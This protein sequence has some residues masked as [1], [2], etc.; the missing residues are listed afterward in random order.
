M[1]VADV[2]DALEGAPRQGAAVD[3]S[4]GSRCVVFRDTAMNRITRELRLASAERP[5]AEYFGGRREPQ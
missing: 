3:D 2:I 5:D 1:S 4:E